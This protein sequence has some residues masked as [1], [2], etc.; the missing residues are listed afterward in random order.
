MGFEITP[1]TSGSEYSSAAYALQEV[2]K[3][4]KLYQVKFVDANGEQVVP[5][6]TVSIGFPIPNGYADQQVAVYRM[7]TDNKVLVRGSL[8]DDYYT[9]ITKSAGAYA[10]VEKGSTITDAENTAQVGDVPQ[11]GDAAQLLPL[12]GVMMSCGLALAG[13]T[14]YAARKRKG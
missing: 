2:G 13:C 8:R 11:T 10:L 7:A 9:V 1:I 12:V 3:K 4:F 14:V 5:N 6:G